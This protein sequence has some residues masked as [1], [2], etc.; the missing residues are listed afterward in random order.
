ME[1]K[2][3]VEHFEFLSTEVFPD[4]KCGLLHGQMLWYEKEDA[5]KDFLA[6]KYNLLVSTTVIEVGIDVP[7]ATVMMINDAHRFGLSQLH[8]LRGRVGRGGEQS[9]CMLA[10]KDNYRFEFN[11]KGKDESEQKSNIIR[12]KT[13]ERTTD[14]FEVAEVDLKLRG[15]GD[16]LG[17]RQSGLPE[18]KFLDLASDGETVTLAKKMAFDIVKSDPRLNK[19]EN[20]VLRRNYI[21]KYHAQDNYFDIA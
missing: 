18:F 20:S 8:Q 1:L 5:M 7:N 21:A 14:G 6:K 16:V 10:T 17:T 19:A 12:L 9:Y 2:S 15:P 11:K 4:Y 13:M 3:A